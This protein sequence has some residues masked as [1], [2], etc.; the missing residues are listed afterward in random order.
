[1]EFTR[2]VSALRTRL[3][4]RQRAWEA[5]LLPRPLGRHALWNPL[6]RHPCRAQARLDLRLS[7]YPDTP[8]AAHSGALN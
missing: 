2:W 3:S 1:M 4:G 7:P 6:R 8:P 5:L